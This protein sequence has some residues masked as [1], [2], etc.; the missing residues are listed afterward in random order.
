MQKKK[1][2]NLIEN[3]FKEEFYAV[4][5]GTI[6]SFASANPPPGA[7]VLNGQ[8]ISNCRELF[9]DF[10]NW[11]MEENTKGTVR[12]ISAS[13]YESEIFSIGMCGGFVVDSENGSIRLPNISNGFIEGSDG[14]NVGNTINAG[15]PNITGNVAN[16]DTSFNSTINENGIGALS[17]TSITNTGPALGGSKQICNL[18]I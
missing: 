18:D 8:I 14:N 13:N 12:I 17:L 9:P 11:V 16:I 15:L 6:F 4:P 3:K 7:F 10:W 5:I 1:L 2:I